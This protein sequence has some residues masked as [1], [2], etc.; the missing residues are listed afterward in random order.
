MAALVSRRRSE[1]PPPRSAAQDHG[2]LPNVD[3]EEPKLDQAPESC[4][5]GQQ[6]F[7]PSESQYRT[8]SFFGIVREGHHR[9]TDSRPSLAYQPV[10]LPECGD[11][12]VK[13][14]V[15]CEPTHNG[16]ASVSPI[17]RLTPTSAEAEQDDHADGEDE[18]EDEEEEEAKLAAESEESIAAYQQPMTAA[19]RRAEKRKARRFRSVLRSF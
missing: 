6:P 8:D 4:A 19:E 9:P 3:F 5:G 13:N 10:F 12:E 16:S 14:Q 17:S 7:I 1:Q 11:N 2:Q 18:E 15:R